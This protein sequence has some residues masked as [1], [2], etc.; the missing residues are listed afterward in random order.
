MEEAEQTDHSAPQICGKCSAPIT[1][2]AVDGHC[3]QGKTM[4]ANLDGKSGE[5]RAI[6]CCLCANDPS[7]ICLSCVQTL[8]LKTAT[9]ELDSA[10]KHLR[11][12]SEPWANT[13]IA[14]MAAVQRVKEIRHSALSTE[15]RIKEQQGMGTQEENIASLKRDLEELHRDLEVAEEE[16]S[17]WI[18]RFKQGR[19]ARDEA[20]RKVDDARKALSSL[21]PDSAPS[22]RLFPHYWQSELSDSEEPAASTVFPELNDAETRDFFRDL[23]SACSH[24][25]GP[26]GCNIWY[27][28]DSKIV[29]VRRIENKDRWEA[30]QCCKRQVAKQLKSTPKPV[31]PPLLTAGVQDFL[32]CA[33]WDSRAGEA[34]LFHGVSGSEADAFAIGERGFSTH[35]AASTSRYG[36][37]MYMTD[38][39]CKAAF[40]ANLGGGGGPQGAAIVLV[41]RVCLGEHFQISE[42]K[43][44]PHATRPPRKCGCGSKHPGCKCGK[45]YDSVVARINVRSRGV[46]HGPHREV[47]VYNADQVSVPQRF[48]GHQCQ[49]SVAS[50]RI[51]SADDMPLAKHAVC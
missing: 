29:S 36:P 41:C 1:D 13:K 34:W 39:F 35:L 32:K 45:F 12:V 15:Q 5:F 14:V 42:A 17:D 19:A 37:G 30:Y 31:C 50:Q 21:R 18:G 33:Q 28:R 48:R 6:L 46:E 49:H 40:Y 10:T 16:M 8:Y 2:N 25:S 27:A 47:V 3:R 26:S 24:S 7:Q 4:P 20:K 22:K 38:E 11:K 9:R 43:G 23:I 44:R 51:W